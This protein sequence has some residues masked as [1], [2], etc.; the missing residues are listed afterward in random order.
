MKTD[1]A[2]YWASTPKFFTNSYRTKKGF[3]YFVHLFLHFRI[4]KAVELLD[5]IVLKNKRVLDIGCG[6]GQ[7]LAY[8]LS[9]ES[10][11]TG[12]D[13]SPKMLNLAKKYLRD[14]GFYNFSL[15]K[16]NAKM[17]PFGNN[18]FDIVMAIGLLE[19]LTTP[20]KVIS[21]ITRVLKPN[22]YAMLSFSK[23][24]SPFFFLRIF[25]GT[26]VRRK[27]FKLPDL[28][29]TFDKNSTKKLLIKNK[30]EIIKRQT[31]MYTE[32]LILCRKH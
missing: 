28:M 9:K 10:Y 20:E 26:I 16:A 5:D 18:H 2:N 19:Y 30:L 14:K 15:I 7:Y 12:V 29:T 24:W 22:G 4:Q 3:L 17:L 25:P 1:T 31:I 21:E 11:V 8:F 23:K 6:E 13:Y 32:W 27:I